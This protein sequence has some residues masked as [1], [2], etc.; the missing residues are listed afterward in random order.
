MLSARHRTQLMWLLYLAALFMFVLSLYEPA[1]STYKSSSKK[2]DG[3]SV[4]DWAGWW[5]LLFGPLGI[6]AGQFAWWANLLMLLSAMP[7]KRSIKLALAAL[8]IPLAASSV[9]M[10]SIPIFDTRY[11]VHAAKPGFYLWLAC[12]IPLLLAALLS[13][14]GEESPPSNA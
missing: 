13:P 5:F 9:L 8:S 14:N 10:T 11:T 7:L 12:P 6:L 3:P 2:F 1:V 4:E